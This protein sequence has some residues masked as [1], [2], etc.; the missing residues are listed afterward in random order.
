MPP[1]GGPR[2]QS[3]LTE[4]EK[5]NRPKVTKGM[6]KRIFSY[7]KPY[8]KQM[9]IVLIAIIISSM[10]NLMPS[11]LTGK[12]IDEGLIGRSMKKLIIFIVLSLAV[13]LGANLIGVL[14]SYMNTW[15]AQ[16]ITYDMRNKMYRHLQKMSQRFYT[17][18]NQGDIIT[19]NIACH[20]G[21]DISLIIRSIETL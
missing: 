18:N 5:K 20:S 13:T 11:V 16:H 21:D 19:R 10:L 14:E 1:M 7:L 12:I 6:L 8:W 17:S 2:R 4:E 15:I 3:F 9:I